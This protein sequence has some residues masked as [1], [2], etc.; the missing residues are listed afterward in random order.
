MADRTEVSLRDWSLFF[1]L[2]FLLAIGSPLVSQWLIL[3]P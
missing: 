3:G 1:F 2:F